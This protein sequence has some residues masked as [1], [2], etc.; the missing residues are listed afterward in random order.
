MADDA[1]ELG[2][3]RQ[4]SNISGRHKNQPKTYSYRQGKINR[5]KYSATNS[6]TR[7]QSPTWNK[8]V[9]SS[10]AKPGQQITQV[11]SK[12]AAPTHA[13]HR[14]LVLNH[15][16][17]SANNG[18]KNDSQKEPSDRWVVRRDRHMQIINSGIY[19]HEAQARTKAV[20]ASRAKKAKDR[21][22]QEKQRLQDFLAESREPAAR[23]APSHC[24]TLDGLSYEFQHNGEKLTRIYGD[25]FEL[26]HPRLTLLQVLM[27]QR[28]PR[29]RL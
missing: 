12:S 24:L 13:R 19:E 18:S 26:S 28:F 16:P 21:N 22:M 20:E 29:R 27:T 4:I 10:V 15:T 6:I 25:W 11:T 23:A 2:L 8:Y 17:S 3:L 1:E 9:S 14:T 7:S 5:H